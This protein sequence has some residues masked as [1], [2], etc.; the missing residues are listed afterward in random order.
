MRLAVAL[1]VLCGCA[2]QRP[3][4]SSS[5]PTLRERTASIGSGAK[6][7][8]RELYKKVAPAVVVVRTS[9][10]YGTGI[11]IDARGFVLTNHHVIADAEQIDFK[12]RAHIE[13]GAL[14]AQGYMEKQPQAYTAWVLKSD[15]AL[16]LAVLKIEGAPANL[17][18]IEVSKD[19]PV[20]GEPVAAVGHGG[21]G[22]L[23]AI[24]D[25]EVMGIGKLAKQMAVYAV[26]DSDCSGDA[27]CL[28]GKKAAE[29]GRKRLADRVPALVI[30]S[31]CQLAPGDSGGPLV[32][33]AGQL[34]GVNAFLQSDSGAPVSSFFHVHVSE[35]R[36]F[37]E[38]VPSEPVVALPSPR[39][40]V[41]DKQP[42]QVDAD[43]DGKIETSIYDLGGAWVV[44][45][46]LS[47]DVEIA[48]TSQSGRKLV[49]RGDVLTME[50]KPGS[51]RGARW[52]MTDGRPAKLAD[53]E[54]L[55]DRSQLPA[56]AAVR[57]DWVDREALLPCGLGIAQPLDHVPDPYAANDWEL[58]DYDRDGKFESGYS[59]AAVVIDPKQ[60]LAAPVKSAPV[61]I[62]R[63]EESG[64]Y[65]VN[66]ETHA[67][68]DFRSGAITEGAAKGQLAMSLIFS[69]LDATERKRVRG[70][71]RQHNA[72]LV[73][74]GSPWPHPV[75]DVG[76][77][78]LAEESGVKGLEWAVVSAAGGEGR[79]SL[80]FELDRE[81]VGGSARDMERRARAGQGTDMAWV[82][83]SACEWFLYDTDRDG[84]FDVMLFKAPRAPIEG[85]RRVKGAIER[86]PELDGSRPV[87][88][89]LFGDAK[90]RDTFVQLAK[91]FFNPDVIE[92]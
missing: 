90:Q 7:D 72:A 86:A 37:L 13:L 65:V 33:R 81:H 54:L 92:P 27:E 34:V 26:A 52:A 31:S 25:G 32:N 41:K 82:Q 47:P 29:E 76:A 60:R 69:G 42:Q 62:M 57:F 44:T 59:R 88:P 14:N 67:T 70:A 55:L 28:A 4:L 91:V 80:M 9:H 63:F 23:W 48:V 49:W 11:V 68:S 43:G 15:P 77:D 39:E 45:A 12:R 8:V 87:R 21:I 46:K 56:E 20:P 2:A 3:A 71:M 38:Q 35:V 19:D 6:G 36:G 78:L 61:A 24:R 17:P 5:A 18:S 85:F 10:G 40:L 89:A 74:E 30:Q 16:D 83:R 75:A 73:S 84:A 51:G 58:E 1:L 66:G 79:S 64:W 50:S 53:D 22:L